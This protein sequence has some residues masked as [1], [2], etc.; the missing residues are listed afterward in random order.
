[1]PNN[2]AKAR[3]SR[4]GN[5]RIKKKE[6]LAAYRWA[7]YRY[8]QPEN[9]TGV[10]LEDVNTPEAI[11]IRRKIA[12]YEKTA[13]RIFPPLNLE[14]SRKLVNTNFVR[15]KCH[16]E[17]A[18]HH[19]EANTLAQKYTPKRNNELIAAAFE[20]FAIDE[21]DKVAAM[22]AA[23]KTLMDANAAANAAAKDAY[24]AVWNEFLKGLDKE[25][26]FYLAMHN[27]I[28]EFSE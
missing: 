20:N 1:M 3:K 6:A 26:L 18:K 22:K 28:P 8:A 25:T 23:Q 27:A 13:E 16:D 15:G 24:Y 12:A 11:G 10:R 4:E 14:L 9:Q 7:L 19:K 2:K 5:L 21:E 17:R